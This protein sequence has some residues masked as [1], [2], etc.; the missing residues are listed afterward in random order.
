M[1]THRYTHMH[2]HNAEK[3][4]WEH[5]ITANFLLPHLSSYP[6][7]SLTFS[8][9]PWD[10]FSLGSLSFPSLAHSSPSSLSLTPFPPLPSICPRRSGLHLPPQSS[11]CHQAGPQAV[12]GRSW[13]ASVL[14]WPL[15]SLAELGSAM[16]QSHRRCWRALSGCV[17]GSGPLLWP[18]AAILFSET[19]TCIN[20]GSS[21]VFSTF[22][23]SIPTK[24]SRVPLG[25]VREG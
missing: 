14:V 2:M 3:D 1:H 10:H 22:L 8:P 23:R 11:G 25:D 4:L 13:A 18:T 9:H 20:T 7:F 12:E 24:V 17:L 15:P 6:V 21:S 19:R 16:A 5:A